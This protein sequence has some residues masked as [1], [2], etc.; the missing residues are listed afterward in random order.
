MSFFES[1]SKM[2]MEIILYIKPYLSIFETNYKIFTFG[3]DNNPEAYREKENIFIRAWNGFMATINNFMKRSQKKSASDLIK[4]R[5]ASEYGFSATPVDWVEMI[6]NFIR[7]FGKPLMVLSLIGGSVIINFLAQKKYMNDLMDQKTGLTA[8]ILTSSAYKDL[9]FNPPYP[10]F[11]NEYTKQNDRLKLGDYF[12]PCSYK[13]YIVSSYG[14]KP[15]IGSIANII[16]AGARVLHFD[17]YE[18][19]VT[20]TTYSDTGEIIDSNSNYIPIV[21]DSINPVEEGIPFI[22]V[23]NAIIQA[24]PF[25]IGNNNPLILYLDFWYQEDDEYP[26]KYDS[27]KTKIVID[28]NPENGT[29]T[30][31]G[32]NTKHRGF[33]KGTSTYS[34][35]LE[36]I[37]SSNF[38]KK[39]KDGYIHFGLKPGTTSSLYGNCGTND[40]HNF[41]DIP[42]FIAMNRLLLI[43]N[44]DLSSGKDSSVGDLA[45]YL[46][47]TVDTLGIEYLT[48]NG[49]NEYYKFNNDFII[50]NKVD[51]GQTGTDLSHK[52]TCNVY[53]N[54]AASSSGIIGKN[55]AVQD[56]VDYHRNYVSMYIPEIETTEDYADW[57][58][59][60]HNPHFL[61]C[62]QFGIQMVFM[63]YQNCFDQ[64]P[65]YIQ[66]FSNKQ[67]IVKS[68]MQN[69]TDQR[70]CLRFISHP[71]SNT[72]QNPDLSYAMRKV[73]LTCPSST[74]E[75][76]FDYNT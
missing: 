49:D 2:I 54:N 38:G 1:I 7:A 56:L 4:E 46:Y 33:R 16:N 24:Q 41:G 8:Y 45:T 60:I 44:I 47:T 51:T 21:R 13:S 73:L 12:F 72:Q 10:Y 31:V 42:M 14:S 53:S 69:K 52:L 20:N 62:Y 70:R 23:L 6:Q 61:D 29:K 59:N 71:N 76:M 36:I 43:S 37:N 39:D 3:E 55:G 11:Y 74:G 19:L 18:D 25:V 63:N 50:N 48:D 32:T 40:N 66:F 75:P 67:F 57:Q 15:T 65:E 64:I 26:L 22:D 35:I 28:Q 9:N 30:Q 34:Q 5:R 68:G 17:V 27:S 58:T